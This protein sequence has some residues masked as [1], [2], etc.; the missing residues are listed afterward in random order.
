MGFALRKLTTSEALKI[1]LERYG[2]VSFERGDD[3]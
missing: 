1:V 2:N 3:L